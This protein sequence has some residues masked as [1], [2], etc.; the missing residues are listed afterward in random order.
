MN[1]NLEFIV[2][3]LYKIKEELEELLIEAEKVLKDVQ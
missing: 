2:K 1:V 3:Q